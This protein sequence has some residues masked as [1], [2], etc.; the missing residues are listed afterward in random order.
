MFPAGQGAGGWR[1]VVV[2]FDGSDEARCAVRWA[3]GEAALLRCPLHLV[4]V[5]DSP[6]PAVAAGWAAMSL[7]PDEGQRRLCA[8]ELRA[9]AD[10]C[11]S[12]ND[13]LAV[14]AA[15]YDGPLPSGLTRHAGGV[16]AALLVVGGSELSRLSR[17]VFG[18]TAGEL[19]RT[20]AQPVV[21]VRQQTPVQE[22]AI[23]TG[24]ATVVAVCDDIATVARVLGSAFDVAERWGAEVTV[25][26]AAPHH[27]AVL[28][29]PGVPPRLLDDRLTAC[30]A[31]HPA[32][33]TRTVIGTDQ[34]GRTVL[35][36]AEDARLV[37][38]GDRRQGVVHRLLSG[39]VSHTALHHAECTVLVV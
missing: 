4:G 6:V 12:T 28:S 25:L 19:V 15:L 33:G 23:A 20:T 2:G 18:S 10:L 17:V 26:T 21:A 35:E 36:H 32:V 14:F 37:V 29:M 30:Q 39:S 16:G 9:E 1:G 5:V 22:A 13:E 8:N 7:G 31:A 3:A 38:V 27:R 24:Y 11:R 34:P